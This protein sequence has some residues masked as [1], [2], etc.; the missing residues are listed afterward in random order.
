MGTAFPYRK[1]GI[2]EIHEALEIA[3]GDSNITPKHLLIS[4]GAPQKDDEGYLDTVYEEI[5]KKCPVS[6]DVM[7]APRG[8]ESI[9]ERLREWG[10]SGL[11]INMEINDEK[12]AKKIMPEKYRVGKDRYL[13]FIEKA[14]KIFGKGAVRSCIILGLEEAE[15]TLEGVRGLARIGCDP[16][17][18]SFKPLQGTLLEDV[19]PPAPWFQEQVY[20]EAEKIV[21]EYGVLLGPRCIPCQHNTL[22]FPLEGGNYFFY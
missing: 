13:K 3:L 1:A 10:C 12:S 19:L 8:D 18:S 21:R 4:G 17:L 20:E 9:L 15:S 22:T 6:V 16:V 7:M 14:V 11:S 2:S 5:I